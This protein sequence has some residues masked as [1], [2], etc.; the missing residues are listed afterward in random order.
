MESGSIFKKLTTVHEFR[1]NAKLVWKTIKNLS[2]TNEMIS[3]FFYAS[4]PVFQN[5]NVTYEQGADFHFNY[6]KMLTIHFRCVEVIEKE[7]HYS[8]TWKN[9]K[10]EPDTPGYDFRYNLF[11]KTKDSCIL[12]LDL[13]FEKDKFIMSKEEEE[14][15]L[16]ERYVMFDR[17]DSLILAQNKNKKQTETI[18]IKAKVKQVFSLISDLKKFQRKVPIICDEVEM[19]DDKLKLGTVFSFKWF[20]RTSLYV[21]LEVKKL[22]VSDEKAVLV[23]ASKER[24]KNVPDQKIKWKITKNGDNSS[25]ITFKHSFKEDIREEMLDNISKTKFKILTKLNLLFHQSYK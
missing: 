9:Y 16:K 8:I 22:E 23:Y 1:S 14:I 15:S 7:N 3:S 17:I 10:T 2:I 11:L 12:V 19:E 6:R 21:K 24:N 25:L 13:V 5:G 4:K 18:E 20:K